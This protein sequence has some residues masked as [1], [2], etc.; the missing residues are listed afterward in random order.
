MKAR[1]RDIAIED[2]RTPRLRFVLDNP[3]GETLRAEDVQFSYQIFDPA[4]NVYLL[5]GDR[6]ALPHDLPAGSSVSF[7]V[8]LSVPNEPGPY[9]LCASLMRENEA[10]AYESGLPFIQASLERERDGS[11]RVRKVEETD[12][13]EDR[14]NHPLRKLGRAI[15]YPFG[16]A[17][18]NRGL[19]Y[20]LVRREIMSRSRGSFAG[21]LW[22]ILNPLLLLLTYFFVFGLVL[23]ARF[24]NDPSPASF[25]LYLLA[26][27][28]PWLAF[29]EAVGRAP[30]VLIEY[31]TLIKKLVF[32]VETLPVNLVYSGLVGELFGAALFTLACLLI[33]GSLPWTLVYLPVV[34]IPQMLFTAAMCWFLAALGVFLRDLSQFIDPIGSELKPLRLHLDPR[35]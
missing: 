9:Q 28:L 25:A 32:P 7:D 5:D 22:T 33:R 20:T 23:K 6:V 29:S 4:T 31:R 15:F 10:W 3:S 12:R 14:R 8:K 35:Q 18:I 26:G 13:R 17:W 30:T 21:S 1:Y 34:L 2:P 11:V 27:M 16:T 19:S 24:G